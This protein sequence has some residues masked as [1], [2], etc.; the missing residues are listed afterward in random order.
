[1]TV[2]TTK[3]IL[4][5]FLR[6]IKVDVFFRFLNRKKSLVIM[7]H[8]ITSKRWDF[9]V[10]TQLPEDVFRRQLQFIKAHYNILSLSEAI[11]ALSD[12]SKFPERTALITFDDGLKN[13]YSI[14]FPLLKEYSV[15]ATI[16]LPVNLIGTEKF[17]W[18][19]ELFLLLRESLI[20]GLS[21]SD[22]GFI[23]IKE[24]SKKNLWDIYFDTVERLKRIPEL[25]RNDYMKE[26]R[27]HIKL[28]RNNLSEDFGMLT[29]NQVIEMKKSGLVDFGVH[30]ANHRILSMLKAD[31]WK[32]EIK[33][34]KE[35]L[36]NILG[37]EVVSFCYPN[38][39]PGVDFDEDHVRYL[40][41]CGYVCAFTTKESLFNPKKEDVFQIGRIPAGN[42][43]T[44]HPSIF[45]INTSG[46]GEYLRKF[47]QKVF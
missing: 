46:L 9:P 27:G 26:M 24:L 45:T 40:K 4:F 12:P 29:W 22:L 39:R 13:N 1:M 10:W 5:N 15:P 42:D 25:R 37:N 8:G 30:T 14:A 31:E 33:E 16:F 19:D 17:L 43:F 6:S 11:S 28:N 36:S 21:I 23:E 2:E 35:K 18:V 47:R 32:K 44:S 20:Q 3:S 34:P 38:G 41:E 7:Y